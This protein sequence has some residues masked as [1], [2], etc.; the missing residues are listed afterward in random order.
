MFDCSDKCMGKSLNDMLF[1]GPDLTRSLVGVLL[2]FRKE[3]VVVMADI[4]TKFYQVAVPNPH[5]SSLRLLW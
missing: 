1:K 3:R 4:E 5:C 2:R